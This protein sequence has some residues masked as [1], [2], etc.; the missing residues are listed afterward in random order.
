MPNRK[1]S[2]STRG[3]SRPM[4]KAS[5]RDFFPR[6]KLRR[7]SG[8]DDMSMFDLLDALDKCKERELKKTLEEYPV[9]VEMLL[10]MGPEK[11]NQWYAASYPNG[12]SCD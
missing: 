9:L 8:D 1:K 11:I 4:L 3:G 6:A 2:K 5:K 7:M 10:E 12:G